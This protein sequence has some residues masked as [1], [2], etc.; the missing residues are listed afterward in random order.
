MQTRAKRTMKGSLIAMSAAAV[1]VG[2]AGCGSSQS[3]A[4][5]QSWKDGY[6]TGYNTENSSDWGSITCQVLVKNDGINLPKDFPGDNR[7]QF[8]AG[9]LSGCDVA[10]HS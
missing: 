2:L 10:K 7:S 4:R 8:D 5:T 6:Q 9:Y 3:A 1:I